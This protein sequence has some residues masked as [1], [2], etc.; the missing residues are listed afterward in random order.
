MYLEARTTTVP[1]SLTID[2]QILDFGEVPVALRLTKEILVKNVGNRDEELRLQSLSPFGGFCVLNAMRTI[3]PGDFKPVVIQFEPLAQQ[4]YEERVVLFSDYTTVSVMVKGIGVRPEVNI[5]PEE[6]LIQFGNVFVNETVEKAFKI[7][8]VS[9]FPV[10][11]NLKSQVH[12]CTNKKKT[13]PFVLIPAT[14]TIPAKTT[15]E[16]KILF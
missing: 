2:T 11:F 4:I 10:K 7:K 6:G 3:S 15:Y 9:S 14:A 5:E 13:V 8:N 12:G 16:V 1:R